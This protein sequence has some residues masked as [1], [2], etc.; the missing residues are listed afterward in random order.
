[1]S[2]LQH[3]YRIK[4]FQLWLNYSGNIMLLF[5]CLYNCVF[6]IPTAQLD[7]S[8]P[9]NYRVLLNSG[10]DASEIHH[11]GR[12]LQLTVRALQPFSN[13]LIRVQ[14]CQTGNCRFVIR[15]TT[16][17]YEHKWLSS[18]K[19]RLKQTNSSPIIKINNRWVHW[20]LLI[21]FNTILPSENPKQF[22]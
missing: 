22:T 21:M 1:M 10:S 14:A 6:L 15:F 11:A 4:T 18:I 20:T 2:A 12:D 19:Q 5:D 8:Q 9:V 13:Y 7:D 16:V 17:Y 3:L